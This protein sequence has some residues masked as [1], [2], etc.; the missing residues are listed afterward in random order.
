MYSFE[1]EELKTLRIWIR[2]FPGTHVSDS[3]FLFEC[4]HKLQQGIFVL[5]EIWRMD[6]EDIFKNEMFPF[7][8]DIHGL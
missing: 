6:S 8:M 2:P 1:I 7:Q 3:L 5:C 4:W